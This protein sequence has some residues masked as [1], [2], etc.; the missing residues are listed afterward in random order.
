MIQKQKIILGL[1]GLILLFTVAGI[2]YDL[3]DKR[4]SGN[5][6]S[7]A[8]EPN[9]PNTNT[10]KQKATN[11]TMTDQHGNN[12]SLSSMIA[13]EKP[14]I[15]NFWASWCPPCKSEMPEFEKVFKEI[16]GE[17]QF[18]MVDVTD[19]RRET[20]E[21]GTNYINSQG[22]TFPVFFDTA[23]EGAAAYGI[24]SIPTTL[25]IDK[26]GYI[27]TEIQGAINEATLWEGIN[28]IK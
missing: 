12:I 17:V 1:A 20:A 26:N 19:R 7:I 16:G 5:D 2:A 25:F 13:N 3:L 15:L 27:V 21:I 23:Q 18:M 28:L 11:F 24:R 14:I 9:A 4:F 10:N 22:Y 6:P 8:P